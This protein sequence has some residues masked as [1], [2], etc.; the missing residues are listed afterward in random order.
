[1]SRHQADVGG[2]VSYG[3]VSAMVRMGQR[4]ELEA[5]FRHFLAELETVG[6][7]DLQLAK[8]RFISLVTTLVISILEI[9][10][11]SDVE[12]TIAHAASEATAAQDVNSLRYVAENYLNHAT[13]CARPNA[14][15]FAQQTIERCQSIIA[16]SYS[17]QLTDEK[18]AERSGLSRSHFR[19][20]FKEVTG[21]PFKRYLSQV[22]LNAAKQ[23]ISETRIPIRDICFDVGYGDLSSFYRAYRTFHGVPPTADRHAVV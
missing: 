3:E 7:G 16:E 18:M 12:S 13:V 5:Y 22:R 23:L 4:T 19:Y 11:P 2:H 8:A 6:T 17:Q 1:M 15:R 20:L 14:N 9:G 10:A 21:M